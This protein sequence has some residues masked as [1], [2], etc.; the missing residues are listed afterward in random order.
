MPKNNSSFKKLVK[1]QMARNGVLHVDPKLLRVRYTLRVWSLPLNI[2][3]SISVAQFYKDGHTTSKP[4]AVSTSSS[5]TVSGL[6]QRVHLQTCIVHNNKNRFCRSKR[7][8]ERSVDRLECMLPVNKLGRRSW[9]RSSGRSV[10]LSLASADS[11]VCSSRL[12]EVTHCSSDANSLTRLSREKSALLCIA[13]L[14]KKKRWSEMVQTQ[15]NR[16][17]M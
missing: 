16:G 13:S 5:S 12:T 11:S 10:L 1:T 2:R 6:N 8:R 14:V 17:R 7:E 3:I 9:R 15:R 4:N